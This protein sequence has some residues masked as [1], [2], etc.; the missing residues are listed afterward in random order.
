MRRYAR[1]EQAGG[2]LHMKLEA[3]TPTGRAVLE[4]GAFGNPIAAMLL[5]PDEGERLRDGLTDWLAT[6]G[7]GAR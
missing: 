4:I 2:Q 7:R 5:D 1:I 6:T 3:D